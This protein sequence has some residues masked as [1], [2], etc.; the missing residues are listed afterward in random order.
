MGHLHSFS[1]NARPLSAQKRVGGLVDCELEEPSATIVVQARAEA[2][3]ERKLGRAG[4]SGE[5]FFAQLFTLH[6]V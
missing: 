3:M 1:L 6:L 2:R 5:L 4:P